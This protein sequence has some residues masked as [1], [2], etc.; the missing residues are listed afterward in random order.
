MKKFVALIMVLVIAVSSMSITAFADTDTAIFSISLTAGSTAD[1][2]NSA[3]RRQKS[4]SS[5]VYVDYNGYGSATNP[6]KFYA[7]VYAS[8]TSTGRLV[9]VST[10]TQSGAMRPNPIVTLGTKGLLKN[11]AIEYISSQVY[12][13][14]FGH[15]Y[16]NLG[17]IARGYWSADVASES[18]YNYYNG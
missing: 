3:S 7:Y 8:K 13:Q 4:T 10:Y 17:G 6:N 14:L 12:V 9:D 1:V 16:S 11:L 2:S 5:S 18:G 15:I